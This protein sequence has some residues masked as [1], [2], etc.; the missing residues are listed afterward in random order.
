[1]FREYKVQVTFSDCMSREDHHMKMREYHEKQ[2]YYGVAPVWEVKEYKVLAENE[3]DARRQVLEKVDKDC[4]STRYIFL[5]AEL[6]DFI[7]IDTLWDVEFKVDDVPFTQQIQ[8]RNEEDIL[9]NIIEISTEKEGMFES[10]EIISVKPSTQYT[11]T[12]PPELF[13]GQFEYSILVNI[14]IDN[15]KEMTFSKNLHLSQVPTVKDI[16]RDLM[17]FIKSNVPTDWKIINVIDTKVQKLT[18]NISFDLDVDGIKAKK[19]YQINTK[20]DIKIAQLMAIREL[21]KEN[22]PNM[23]YT[24]IECVITKTVEQEKE[25]EEA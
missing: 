10:V 24:K 20:D 1:M 12:E 7:G 8:G 15:E 21:A 17:I 6:N 14:K 16:K 4:P 9:L 18:H 2:D 13:F 22:D 23:D 5:K 25:Y 11:P 3:R 19:D